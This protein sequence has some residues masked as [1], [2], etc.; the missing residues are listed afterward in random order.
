[1][2]LIIFDCDGVLV[3]SEEIY[4]AA[5]LAF[6][7]SAGVI[8]ERD[9]YTDTFMGL[10][11]PMWQARL[12]SIIAE[13]R[14]APLPPNFFAR[15]DDHSTAQLEIHLA[16]LPGARHTIGGLTALRCVA[17]STPSVRLRWKLQET[18]LI[19]LFDPHIF[20]SDMVLNGK[21][22][23]D[24][25]LHAAAV[26]GVQPGDCVVVEDSVNGVMAGKAA[27]MQVIGFT[28]GAH[29]AG[30]HGDRLAM[31]GADRIVCSYGD[32]ATALNGLGAQ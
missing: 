32:L 24:L 26:M 15:L 9:V 19:G 20:S 18:G 27:G 12:Q 22:A 25:F 13:K 29:C 10:S 1:M 7:A 30:N 21:P 2:T 31:A 8:L 28:A 5:E 3:N 6:L 11:P 23:P 17:S 14:S 16:A 4:L